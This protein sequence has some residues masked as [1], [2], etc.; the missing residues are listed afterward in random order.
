[1]TKRSNS[2]EL[3][4]VSEKKEFTK[5]ELEARQVKK[6]RVTF[7][8]APLNASLLVKCPR[9]RVLKRYN[10]FNQEAKQRGFLKHPVSTP[11]DPFEVYDINSGG[12]MTDLSP[13]TLGPV[14]NEFGE[15][16]GCNIEDCWQ[17]RKVW[18][19]HLIKGSKFDPEATWFWKQGRDASYKHALYDL[20]DD[21]WFPQWKLWSDHISACGTAQ[22]HRMKKGQ[23]IKGNPNVPLASYYRGNLYPYEKARKLMYIRWYADL[24]KKT[25]SYQYLKSRFDAGTPLILLDPDGVDRNT[26]DEAWVTE[27]SARE[28]INDPG[29]IFGHGFVLACLFQG[30]DVWSDEEF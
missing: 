29:K 18:A 28:R 16:L 30:I 7:V 24:V 23:I 13:M 26:P 8:A 3:T 21:S 20:G 6:P 5:E 27:A 19:A 17:G 9:I 1:M 14:V 2:E 10:R 12:R 11:E 4:V 25:T 15:V 22:R